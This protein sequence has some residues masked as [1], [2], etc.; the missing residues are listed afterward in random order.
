MGKNMGSP[1]REQEDLP[2]FFPQFMYVTQGDIVGTSI[3][4]PMR[5]SGL[6]PGGYGSP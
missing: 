5:G 6:G 3:R 4:L 1:N 2:Y